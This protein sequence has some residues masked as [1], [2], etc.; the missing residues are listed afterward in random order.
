MVLYYVLYIYIDVFGG[1]NDRFWVWK[2][3]HCNAPRKINWLLIS[4]H[5]TPLSFGQN[6]NTK[7]H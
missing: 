7:G 4:W 6:G 1:E 2:Y 3:T 5:V